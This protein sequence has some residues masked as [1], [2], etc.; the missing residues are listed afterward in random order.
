[1]DTREAFEKSGQGHVEP[2]WPD[3]L[4][5][6]RDADDRLAEARGAQADRVRI[7]RAQ[8]EEEQKGP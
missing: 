6:L 4:A 3:E 7:Q 5:R 2:L 1:M 8:A